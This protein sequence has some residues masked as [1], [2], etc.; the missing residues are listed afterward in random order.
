MP[1]ASRTA[2]QQLPAKLRLSWYY[3]DQP[4]KAGQQWIFTVKL[5]RVHGTMNPGGFDYERWL[6]TEGIGATGYVRPSPKPVLL[7][8]DSAWSS[9]SVWRQSITDQ[10]SSTLGNSPSLALIKALTIGDGNSITQEQ[11]EVFR[12][13]G[14]TH[15]VVIS[16][17][18]IG[19]IAGLVYFLVLKLWAWTGWLAWSPQK[20][21]A[22]SA[23]LVAIFYS[24]LAGFSVPT[25][26]SVVMLSIA[27]T[28][29]ILQRNSRPFNTLAIALFAVLIVDP[30]AVL[31][32][33]FWL[34]FLAVSLIVYAVSGRLGKLGH[35]WGA[36]KL[37]WVTSVGLSPLLLLFFQQVS[38]IAPLANLIAV[39]VISLLVV[40]LSLLAVMIMFISPTLAGK[41]FYLVDHCVARFMVAVGSFGGN[42]A[43]V[44]KSCAAL[45][46]GI[47]FRCAGYFAV[48][49][50][51]RHSG[52]VAESGDVFAAGVY[53]CKTTRNRRHQHDLAG[54]RARLIGRRANH[55]SSAGLRYRR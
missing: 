3:P 43:G 10:L 7:G 48:A 18:H 2:G 11:W 51:G 32:A 50:S 25:Q 15:L 21:A 17:S 40:P 36:I 6:F 44:D 22:V 28:A 33:G 29:I 26:R 31:S 30:L 9:I 1:Q 23:V 54:C 8:R 38:L 42:S 35:I 46:L 34:S 5:K 49:C 14:T 24:G 41:L 12:K 39:P 53:R 4:I 45:V 13:T 19:L 37:H 16:G 20:V 47:A 27:M 55:S 52:A